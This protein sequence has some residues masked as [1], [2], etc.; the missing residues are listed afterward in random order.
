[1]NKEYVRYYYVDITETDIVN[2]R[3]FISCVLIEKNSKECCLS[4]QWIMFY[5][6]ERAGL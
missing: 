2:N 5:I 1:M 3:V 6:R 4:M